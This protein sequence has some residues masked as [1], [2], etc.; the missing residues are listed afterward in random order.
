MK[1]VD[2]RARTIGLAVALVALV[3]LAYGRV[4]GHGFLDWDDPDYVRDN[5][6][7]LESWT[8][9]V[10]WAFTTFHAANWHPLTW[11][12][13]AVDARV[14]GGWAGGAHLVSVALH[15]ANAVLLFLFFARTTRRET[16]SAIVAALFAVHPL[17][18]E[19]VA[20]L[21]ERKDVLSTL[22]FGIALLLYARYAKRPSAGRMAAV[23]GALA[24]GLMAKPMLVSVP[25]VLTILDAWPL[26]RVGRVTA[27]AAPKPAPTVFAG[28]GWTVVIEKWP[29]FAFAAA[30]CAVTL[31]AQRAGGAVRSV[32][33]VPLLDRLANA[34]LA[35]ATYLVEAVWP[36]GLAAF[37]PL[38]VGHVPY[39]L[40]ALAAVLL[41]ALT[42]AAA[43]L[44]GTRPYLLAGWLWYLV[45]LAPVIGLVQ[46]GAQAH[47]DRYTY[48]P[49]VGP[50][51]AIVW[52]AADLAPSAAVRR[53]LAAVAA[54][55][56]VVLAALT[57]VQVGHWRTTTELFAHTRA[58]TGENWFA[59]FVLGTAAE[60]DGRLDEAIAQ[61]R[62]ALALQPDDLDV[63]NN[64]GHA[65]LERGA[66][67]EAV[68]VLEAGAAR[69]PRHLALLNNLGRALEAQ[70]RADDAVAVLRRAEGV[71]PDD[72]DTLNNLGHAL[73]SAGRLDE[74]LATYRRAL[75]LRARFPL[76]LNNLGAALA[77][78]GRMD[79]AAR[80]FEQA[81]AIDPLDPMAHYNLGMALKL[82]GR[83][84]EA[85]VHFREAL[86]LNPNDRDARAQL[87]ALRPSR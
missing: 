2:A 77:T 1:E 52:L 47:A 48:I 71:R 11:L 27:P 13:H 66:A 61:Y 74:A 28:T 78:Q 85:I 57:A 64:L 14:F 17:H 58:V 49:L 43:R 55:V 76:A 59:E 7:L 29:L 82:T 38:R 63:V 21:A 20:W 33:E 30:S 54:A 45:T 3:V 24:C 73:A 65:L 23:A 44:R 41:V 69:G 72:A 25:L 26:G 50:F 22:F 60:K 16:E 35:A 36:V 9:L 79:E 87:S 19:S 75:A 68:R 6:W 40:A 32:A 81:V 18:V 67:D 31:A 12:S 56:V 86:R 34:V 37:H 5:P 53:A 83:P 39:G 70:N 15:A 51:F 8:R 84:A 10:P 80:S 62:R 46:V 42:A 4:A